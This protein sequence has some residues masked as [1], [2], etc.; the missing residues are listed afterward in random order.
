MKS[1]EKEMGRL[2]KK[3]IDDVVRIMRLQ[4][5][6]REREKIIMRLKKQWTVLAAELHRIALYVSDNLMRVERLCDKA[7]V[8]LAELGIGKHREQQ[9]L[10]DIKTRFKE[11]I[12]SAMSRGLVTRQDLENTKREFDAVSLE[13]IVLIRE[14]IDVL[15]E[16][17]EDLRDHIRKTVND[18]TNLLSPVERKKS[19]TILE[20]TGRYERIGHLLSSLLTDYPSEPRPS[21]IHESAAYDDII[22]RKREEMVYSLLEQIRQERR[23]ATVDRRSLK[24][25]RKSMETSYG[26]PERRSGE[27]RRSGKSRRKSGNV[28]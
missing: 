5:M 2:N 19:E 16:S 25:R 13:M 26:G 4:E 3:K 1:A 18:I 27:D 9:L 12:K 11:R 28:P 22:Q 20:S 7:V 15:T 17:Y 23:C 6:I 8:H 24:E 21:L 10:A 14:D